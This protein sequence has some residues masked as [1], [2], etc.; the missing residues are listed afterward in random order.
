MRIPIATLKA[1]AAKFNLSHVVMFARAK[2]G[3]DH[4]V[5]YGASIEQCDEA[6]RFGNSMKQALGWPESLQAQ[7]ARVKAL[8]ARINE[9]EQALGTMHNGISDLSAM[10]EKVLRGNIAVFTRV[11]DHAVKNGNRTACYT[12]R[13]YIEGWRGELARRGLKVE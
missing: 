3:L 5:T 6:A 10:D 1:V 11:C 9:L 13:M 4:V 8:Q 2:D 12:A 7:P